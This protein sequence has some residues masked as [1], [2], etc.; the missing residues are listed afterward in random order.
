MKV[1]IVRLKKI[2]RTYKMKTAD[3]QLGT[4]I[5]YGVGNND[6]CPKLNVDDHVRISKYKKCFCIWKHTKL[7][8]GSL[9]GKSL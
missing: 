2:H 3:V 5:E 4:Y 7:L 8:W 1:Y 9:C 6:K